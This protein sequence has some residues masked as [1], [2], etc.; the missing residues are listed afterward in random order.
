MLPPW[1]HRRRV[2]WF[3]LV[4]AALGMLAGV[5]AFRTDAAVATQLIVTSGGI[6]VT[7]V[8]AYVGGAVIDDYIHRDIYRG[9]PSDDD[10]SVG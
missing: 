5:V 7:V 6:L 3:A 8:S 1:K 10:E 2:I 4:L 9:G